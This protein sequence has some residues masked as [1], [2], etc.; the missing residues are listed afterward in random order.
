[1]FMGK[2]LKWIKEH[3][4]TV[5][6][7]I[8]ATIIFPIIAIHILFKWHS[9]CYWIEAEWEAGEILGYFGDVLSFM[10]TV[11][12]G[13][14]AISQTETSNKL[15]AEL[16]KIERSR[17]KPCLDMC[18]NQRYKIF[19]DDDMYNKLD[20]ISGKDVLMINLLYTN[21]P[22]TGIEEDAA[23]IELSVVNNGFSDIRRIFLKDTL[24]YLHLRELDKYQCEKIAYFREGS[25]IKIDENKKLYIYVKCELPK[26]GCS[27]NEWIKQ[28]IDGL[29]TPHI[30]FDLEIETVAG[31]RY[32]EKIVC[33]S[34]WENDMESTKMSATRSI[35]VTELDVQEKNI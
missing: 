9:H 27:Y 25:S 6:C 16:L 22:R 11:V 24:F 14:V 29:L 5:I 4:K 31:N 32:N 21:N 28:N 8:A 23:L 34:G 2:F 19:F 18:P 10:G 12:L 17:Q 13:C 15:S 30:E 35:T 3:K 20:E 1:M 7:I 26:D 33:V